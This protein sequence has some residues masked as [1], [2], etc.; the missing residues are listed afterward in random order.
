LSLPSEE[1]R[2]HIVH[3]PAADSTLVIRSTDETDTNDVTVESED[4]SAAETLALPG[5][6]PN[7]VVTS[8]TFPDVDSIFVDGEHAGDIQ[9]GT[10]DGTGAIDTELLENPL[11]G[12]NVDEVS[13]VEGIPPLGS[14][15]RAAPIS[16]NGTTFLETEAEFAN[17]ELGERLHVLDLSVSLDTSREALASKRR[18]TID[19]GQRTV[20]FDADLAGPF[21]S[22]KLIKQHFRRKSG[23]LVY[24]FGDPN[25]DPDDA[26][27]KIV[28][29]NVEIID[30]PDQTRTAGDTNFIPSVTFQATGDPAIEIINDS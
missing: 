2:S 20:E 4:G 21:E 1:V 23:D 26:D 9:V 14:G 24:A 12:V 22:A 10:D 11:T 6:S 8:A 15:S 5:T 13:S 30:A 28:A 25:T 19:V 27:R 3:Q 18:Q 17:A 7:A 29:K 16:G